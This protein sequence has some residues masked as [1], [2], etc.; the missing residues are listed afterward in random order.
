MDRR[1]QR[2]DPRVPNPVAIEIELE[3]LQASKFT[4]K[5]DFAHPWE[6]VGRRMGSPCEQALC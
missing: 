1:G 2:R 5:H 4:S 6:A 3:D